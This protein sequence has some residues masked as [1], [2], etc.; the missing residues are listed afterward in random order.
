MTAYKKRTIKIPV[1]KDTGIFYEVG[2]ASTSSLFKFEPFN[3]I[4]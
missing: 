4:T 3:R 2:K 1:S